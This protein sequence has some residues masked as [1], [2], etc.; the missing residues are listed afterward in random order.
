M[1]YTNRITDEA[2]KIA[3]YIDRILKGA[4]PADLP[5]EQHT[6]FDVHINLKTARALG[7]AIPPS[8]LLR[9]V[10]TCLAPVAAGG[11]LGVAQLGPGQFV[12]ARLR[13][14]TA[15]P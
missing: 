1:S 11:A 9:A 5:V 15:Q 10:Q 14:A 8:L 13:T 3:R 2:P 6:R 7:L 4:R 12:G